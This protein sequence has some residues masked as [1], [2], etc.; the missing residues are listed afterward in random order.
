MGR[1]DLHPRAGL[2]Q[3][4]VGDSRDVPS[5][6]TPGPPGLPGTG[7][8][9]CW[10]QVSQRSP[11]S[12]GGH[13]QRPVCR[14]QGPPWHW[15]PGVVG[16]RGEWPTQCPRVFTT[17][18]CPK[19]HTH[20]CSPARGAP[21][22]QGHTLGTGA[23]QSLAGSGTAH[24]GGGIRSPQQLVHRHMV[25]SRH[26]PRSQSVRPVAR[27]QCH[28]SAQASGPVSSP[29]STIGPVCPAPAH[30]APPSQAAL[31]GSG[32]S[33]ALSHPP[34]TGSARYGGHRSPSHRGSSH[35]LQ[36]VGL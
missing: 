28:S 32:H 33:E 29:P 31:P 18:W 23:P 26:S 22:G 15:Q 5:Q 8:W 27:V 36:K 11:L 35:T 13:V 34:C 25:G 19:G 7:T 6:C 30:P 24:S 2:E 21:S 12:P 9:C 1:W 17:P 3:E 4:G 16:G 14:S 20:A 10:L